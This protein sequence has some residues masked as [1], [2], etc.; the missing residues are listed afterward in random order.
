[1]AEAVRI[2]ERYINFCKNEISDLTECILKTYLNEAKLTTIISKLQPDNSYK[3]H[4]LDK[5]QGL[6]QGSWSGRLEV[7]A[8]DDKP[9][10]NYL[11]IG[12]PSP[13]KHKEIMQF[14][15]NSLLYEP[16][17]KIGITFF[18]P[19]YAFCSV[20]INETNKLLKKVESNEDRRRIYSQQMS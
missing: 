5:M 1:M 19:L 11:R 2:T 4:I 18:L 13:D 9:S 6:Q 8:E 16:L 15:H 17:N 3:R 7:A 12:I 20:L 14:W 10:K